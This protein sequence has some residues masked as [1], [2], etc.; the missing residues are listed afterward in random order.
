[1][2]LVRFLLAASV[3]I[4]H[5][6]SAFGLKLYPGKIAVELFFMISGFY[7]SLILSG[8][9]RKRDWRGVVSFYASRFLRLWPTFLITT[10][11]VNVWLLFVY[12]YLARPP[13]SAGPLCEWMDSTIAC[14]LAQLSNVFMIGQDVSSLFHVSPEDV[15]LT[16]GAGQ[17]DG[18]VWLGYVRYIVQAWS[19]GVEIWFYLLAP[20]LMLLP[21]M[22]L[23]LLMAAS[24]ALRA[25]MDVQGLEVY[26][27]FPPQLALFAVGILAQRSVS[28][29][30]LVRT[31][32]ALFSLAIIALGA[33]AFGSVGELDQR[34]KWL[35][36]GLV[37]LTTQALFLYTQRSDV[38]RR[39][40]E[41]SYPIYITHALV[42]SVLIP[43]GKRL[44]VNIGAELLLAAV[45][46]LSWLLY[47]YVDEP[48]G[49]WRERFA[50]S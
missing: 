17:P 37:G 22:L 30:L 1:M 5:S 48:I 20:F 8:K 10:V 42:L 41:L 13:A 18:W 21:T 9:Y 47:R 36:Y 26:F 49:R 29:G 14:A 43:L 25:W 16:F 46:P 19:I 28:G 33:L 6:A 44:G 12:V 11:A 3:V 40:G 50:Q 27:F 7:M 31:E 23:V 15:R 45:I 32:V 4:G 38:D 34:Y 35:L 2:G 39:I 24:L